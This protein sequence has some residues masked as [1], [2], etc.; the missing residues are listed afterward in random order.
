MGV[1]TE[2]EAIDFCKY[3]HSQMPA[4]TK[5]EGYTFESY[6]NSVFL[7]NEGYEDYFIKVFDE[8]SDKGIGLYTYSKDDYQL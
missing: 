2:Q 8:T 6:M 4:V 3:V 7:A 5:Y 1:K